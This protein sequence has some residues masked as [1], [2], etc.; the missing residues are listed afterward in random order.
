MRAGSRS[1][2]FRWILDRKRIICGNR[3]AGGR[4]R[5]FPSSSWVLSIFILAPLLALV[6]RSLVDREGQFT[7]NYYLALSELRRGSVVYVP[8]LTAVRNSVGYA[9]LTVGLACFLGLLT[10][11]LLVRPGRSACLARPHFYAAA[12][13]LGGDAGFW[14]C[15]DL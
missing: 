11:T 15:G 4:K 5:P 7:L 1:R 6:W 13:C 14:L 12:G 2:R 10:T 9:L 3:R 8:P